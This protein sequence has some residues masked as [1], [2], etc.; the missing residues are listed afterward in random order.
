MNSFEVNKQFGI[1]W[2]I[3]L[4]FTIPCDEIPDGGERGYSRSACIKFFASLR[5]ISA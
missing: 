1:A 3:G 5:P 4:S 2:I